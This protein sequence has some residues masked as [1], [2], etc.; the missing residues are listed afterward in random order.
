MES[1]FVIGPTMLGLLVLAVAFHV[2]EAL[3]DWTPS[4]FSFGVFVWSLAPYAVAV[5]IAVR[6]RQPLLGIVPASLALLLDLYTLI[7]VRYVSHSSTAAL[8]F[9]ALPLWNLVLVVPVGVAGAF[10]WLRF[11]NANSRAP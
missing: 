7:V 10:L 6:T 4:L 2:Y 1:R 8:A 11:R 3:S 5:I 9:L